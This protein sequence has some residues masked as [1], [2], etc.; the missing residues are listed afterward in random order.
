MERVA[1]STVVEK[2]RRPMSVDAPR[3]EQ[4]ALT[5]DD[6]TFAPVCAAVDGP[7]GLSG[8]SAKTV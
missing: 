7:A 4:C 3:R 5:E 2:E 1:Q 8:K 6:E